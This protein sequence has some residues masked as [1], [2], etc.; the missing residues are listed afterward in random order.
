MPD[1]NAQSTT[2]QDPV[3]VSNGDIVERMTTVA[4]DDQTITPGTTSAPTGALDTLLSGTKTAVTRLPVDSIRALCKKLL[5]PPLGSDWDALNK[6][7]LLKFLH[8]YV[9]N[10]NM[11]QSISSET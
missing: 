11:L 1:C 9:S 6:A 4:A 2:S 8:Q 5:A 10:G 7:D 3:D